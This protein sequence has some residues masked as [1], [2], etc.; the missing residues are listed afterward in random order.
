M[1]YLLGKKVLIEVPPLNSN[2]IAIFRCHLRNLL[3]KCGK[4][5]NQMLKSLPGQFQLFYDFFFWIC[6]LETLDDKLAFI[7]ILKH[8]SFYSEALKL[9][10]SHTNLDFSSFLLVF[11][12]IMATKLKKHPYSTLNIFFFLFNR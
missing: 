11:F 5:E 6:F 8:F 9:S 1:L 4:I 10:P 3:S 12:M 2:A 7:L